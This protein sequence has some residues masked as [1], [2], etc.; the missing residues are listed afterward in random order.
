MALKYVS[1]QCT[2]CRKTKDSV[3]DPY[4]TIPNICSI[5]PGCLGKLLFV[6]EKSQ[7]DVLSPT[8]KL[9]GTQSTNPENV[10]ALKKEETVSLSTSNFG[11]LAIAI[12]WPSGQTAVPAV[13]L[14][15]TQRKAYEIKYQQYIF[16]TT[17]LTSGISSSTKD[18]SGKFLR[19]DT[20]AIQQKRVNILVN[21]VE[22]PI[23][24]QPNEV[25]LTPNTVTFN[26]PIPASSTVSVIVYSEAS[27]IERTLF[28]DLNSVK[29][30]TDI[31]FGSWANIG[32]AALRPQNTG[33]IWYIYSCT[34]LSD[35]SYSTKSKIDALLNTSDDSVIFS[36][37]ELS[38]V[39]FLLANSPYSH[40]DRIY[41]FT[42]DADKLNDDYSITSSS[43]GF[44]QLSVPKEMATEFYP[45]IEIINSRGDYISSDD[46]SNIIQT[47]TLEKNIVSK[48]IIGPI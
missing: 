32:K 15:L 27:T 4:R 41:N 12:L 42:V 19:F 47:T 5:T 14:K 37:S 1:Y 26:N 20:N 34:F 8:S 6:S 31:S 22:K 18:I 16:R 45:P 11:S 13:K 43:S 48:K 17:A 21:G 40:V 25:T 44:I 9:I 23:G 28:F 36:E 2:V 46:Y 33:E 38:N 10:V 24:S 7:A 29:M 3:E 39:R 35:I 30:N